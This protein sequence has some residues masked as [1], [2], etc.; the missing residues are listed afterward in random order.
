MDD[1]RA[2]DPDGVKQ[3]CARLRSRIIDTVEHTGGHLSSSLGAVELA[4]ALH[5]VFDSSQ[6][7]ILWDVGHQAYAHKLLTGRDEAFDT[8]RQYGG[9]SGFPDPEES[10]HDAYVAG[11]AGNALSAALGLALA[12]DRRGQLHEVVAVVGDGSLT[13]GMSY[14]ALNHAGH[15]GS[16]LVIVLNDNGMSISPTAGSLARRLHML[17]TGRTYSGLKRGAE[18]TLTKVPL[19]RQVQWLVDRVK[20]G[21]K[22]LVVPVMLFEELGITYLGPVDGHDVLSIEGL[23]QRA[24]SLRKPV[25]V[26]VVT[27]KGKGYSPAEQDPVAYHGLSPYEQRAHNGRSFSGAF[28]EALRGH[29]A[30]DPRVVVVTAAMLD[31]TGLAKIAHDFPGRVIDV[32]ISEQHAVTLA[33]GLAAGG[34]RPVVAI[35]STFLQRAFDQIMHDVCLPNLPVVFAIDRAGIVGEDGKTHQGI[36]DLGYLGLMPHMTVL[37][38]RDGANLSTMLDYALHHDGP[39]ALRYPRAVLPEALGLGGMWEGEKPA[40]EVVRQGSD[41]LLIAVGSMVSHALEAA[42][43][44]TGLGLEVAVMD[45]CVAHPIDAEAICAEAAHYE[46][47]VTLEEHVLS[48]GFGSHVVAALQD[49][50]LQGVRVQRLAVPDRF[51][52]HGSRETLLTE[53]GLDVVGIRRACLAVL[54]QTHPQST[55]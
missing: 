41:L 29:L 55:R 34:L 35:Y 28:S 13:A 27:R 52:P 5:R 38:P 32:G 46:A 7:R 19:G 3:L 17:R 10:G 1:V 37:A 2:L 39:V 53:L 40:P 45:A 14:E 36:F 25:V 18:G 24:R 21:A 22:S 8:L 26:H 16:P 6:D 44:L 51:V 49:A 23:L 47:V 12:R 33:G 15:A 54:Q 9:L 42:E 48:G 11:H 30:S 50:G 43:G 4:V 20:V 31:G